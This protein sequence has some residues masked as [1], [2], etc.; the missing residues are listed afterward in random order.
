[1]LGTVSLLIIEVIITLMVPVAIEIETGTGILLDAVI[2]ITA[3]IKM[4]LV[5][6]LIRQGLEILIPTF[7]TIKDRQI[8]VIL[9]RLR[10]SKSKIVPRTSGV[11]VT[12]FAS[13][14]VVLFVVKSDATL[15]FICL[16]YTSPSPRDRTRS[17]M[18]SSA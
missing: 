16:L 6:H 4:T 12:L 9:T 14:Q 5:S 18:P 7:K 11:R 10:N 1:M 13:E 8:L 15:D 17:R 3:R 2:T